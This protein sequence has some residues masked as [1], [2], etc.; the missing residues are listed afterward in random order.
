[1][2]WAS[3][4]AIIE[5]V[6]HIMVKAVDNAELEKSVATSILAKMIDKLRDSDWDTC[7]ET[8]E[9][10]LHVPFVVGAFAVNG[11]SLGVHD[12]QGAKLLARRVI[13]ANADQWHDLS[14]DFTRNIYA[15]AL[16][17]AFAPHLKDD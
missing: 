10:W 11:I 15:E 9:A 14:E 5:P 1:M 8:L 17:D 3:G 12:Y 2:G 4:G 13:D 7:D 16:A 6:I